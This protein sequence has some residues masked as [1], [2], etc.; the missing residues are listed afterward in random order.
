MVISTPTEKK[1]HFYFQKNLSR[2]KE[3][4]LSARKKMD[5]Q[6]TCYGELKIVLN[7]YTGTISRAGNICVGYYC[8]AQFV[9]FII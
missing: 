7:G 8:F 1:G 4:G 6:I 9:F 2:K 5:A 3:I